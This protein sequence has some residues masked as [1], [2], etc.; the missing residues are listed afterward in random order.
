MIRP[1]FAILGALVVLV[2]W[3]AV[4]VV[5]AGGDAALVARSLADS[6]QR[7]RLPGL[8][9]RGYLLAAGLDKHRL[10]NGVDR[11][12]AAGRQ[13]I[14][15]LIGARLAAARLLLQSGYIAAAERIALEGAR[16]DFDD[17]Q[18]RALLLE[19]RLRGDRA[20]EARRELMLR[21]LQ[22]EEPQLLYLLGN[23]FLTAAAGATDDARAC[24]ARALQLDPDHVPTLVALA[25]LEHAEGHTDLGRKTLAQAEAAAVSA[26]QKEL[27][28]RARHHL[29]ARS[30]PL[31]QSLGVWGQA[32]GTSAVLAGVYLAFL[33]L[34]TWRKLLANTGHP[35]S[36]SG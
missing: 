29:S 1:R 18:A 23:S 27:V 24:Y 17:R 32:H 21:L 9:A 31:A 28:T 4:V 13:L 12:S 7:C 30:S 16:A 8:A 33:L 3:L 36:T 2:G 20:E 22:R 5:E 11:H 15:R 25:K 26:D 10:D 35:T 34:P 6:A 14:E 19:V